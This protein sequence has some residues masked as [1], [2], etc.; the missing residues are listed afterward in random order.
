MSDK[1]ERIEGCMDANKRRR[2]QIAREVDELS[3]EA[4][5]L[6]G[7]YN[8]L[9]AEL[10][11]ESHDAEWQVHSYV[12]GELSVVE[13]DSKEQALSELTD[14]ASEMCMADMRED[15]YDLKLIHNGVELDWTM[16]AVITESIPSE[17]R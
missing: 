3:R 10:E 17:E 13:C 8:D 6:S 9:K 14:Y 4:S 5:K 16:R 11:K 15:Y 7:E 1:S 2:E 12:D